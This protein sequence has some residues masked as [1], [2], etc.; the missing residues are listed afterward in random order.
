MQQQ[1]R[2]TFTQVTSIATPVDQHMSTNPSAPTASPFGSNV[3]FVAHSYDQLQQQQQQQ[4]QQMLQQQHQQMQSQIFRG[5]PGTPSQ[6]PI[7]SINSYD[8]SIATSGGGGGGGG[9]PFETMSNMMSTSGQRDGLMIVEKRPLDLSV[10]DSAADKVTITRVHRNMINLTDDVPC[11][12]EK[13]VENMGHAYK[14][15]F[16]WMDEFWRY[17]NKIINEKI[18]SIPGVENVHSGAKQ[19]TIIVKR[20]EGDTTSTTTN[21]TNAAIMTNGSIS[22]GGGQLA[23]P[24]FPSLDYQDPVT[25]KLY[26]PR[27]DQDAEFIRFILK[28]HPSMPRI[29]KGLLFLFMKRIQVENQASRKKKANR[30]GIRKGKDKKGHKSRQ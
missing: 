17:D 30:K 10:V 18:M 29:Q 6:N 5:H 24:N 15:T 20:T 22:E 9:N 23:D 28:R 7:F 2:G 13:T 27:T 21:T 12:E 11:F 16:K 25:T 26:Q 4:H 1:E 8:N 3:P 19:I 14:V